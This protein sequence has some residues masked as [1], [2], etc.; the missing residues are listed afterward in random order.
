V[1]RSREL[2]T[3]GHLLGYD[4]G[5]WRGDHYSLISDSFVAPCWHPPAPDAFR[6]LAKQ[7][8]T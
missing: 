7:Y 4:I 3:S 6:T 1:I 8:A 2:D 5:Y